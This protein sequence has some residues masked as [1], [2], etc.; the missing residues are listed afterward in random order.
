MERKA[1]F[2]A[3]S[4]LQAAPAVRYTTDL[5]G[6]RMEMRATRDGAATGTFTL[7]GMRVGLLTVGG[8][9]YVRWQKGSPIGGVSPETASLADGKWITGGTASGPMTSTLTPRQL[10]A[11]VTAQL[12]QPKTVFP[13]RGTTATVDGVQT[14]KAA[15]PSSDVYI[16]R[17]APYRV[18]RISP[19]RSAPSL[20]PMP[21]LPSD[22][23]SLPTDLPSL[24]TDLPSLPTDLP[25]LPELG[26]NQAAERASRSG[27]R[28]P[29][30][31]PAPVLPGR[32]DGP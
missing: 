14:W 21:T 20:P 26:L 4:A 31:A 3:A 13:R 1:F 5:A 16:T 6:A 9:S 23:P 32:I 12:K 19:K 7:A 25:S 28:R 8:K 10:G 27:P 30:S 17:K 18:V 15:T 2:A 24:P 22:L 29:P 11:M